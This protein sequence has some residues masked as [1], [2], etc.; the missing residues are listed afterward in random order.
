M[1][2]GIEDA[3]NINIGNNVN[4]Q[5]EPSPEGK[6]NTRDKIQQLKRLGCE[7]EDRANLKILRRL[8]GQNMVVIRGNTLD[9]TANQTIDSFR[10]KVT[11]D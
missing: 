1:F 4:S 8:K 11:E 9:H 2:K 5:P 6:D 3:I 10:A 7:Y